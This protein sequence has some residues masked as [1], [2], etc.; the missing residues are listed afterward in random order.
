MSDQEIPPAF[1]AGQERMSMA[2][3][4]HTLALFATLYSAVLLIR[5]AG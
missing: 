5:F 4:I 2:F 1:W 3:T